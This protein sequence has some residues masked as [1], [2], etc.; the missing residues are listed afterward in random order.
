MADW[1]SHSIFAT[2]LP[3][4]LSEKLLGI[5]CAMTSEGIDCEI[6]KVVI[7]YFQNIASH[8]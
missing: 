4:F 3:K 8:C 6:I 1:Q 2:L 5:N 7:L